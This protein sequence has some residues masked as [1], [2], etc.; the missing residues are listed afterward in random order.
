MIA[1]HDRGLSRR[2]RIAGDDNMRLVRAGED[3]LDMQPDRRGDQGG[4]IIDSSGGDKGARQEEGERG[5]CD[6]QAEQPRQE[7]QGGAEG[8]AEAF[9]RRRR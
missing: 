8:V 4:S 2:Q 3:A 7:M 5:V 9:E 6:D 1:D